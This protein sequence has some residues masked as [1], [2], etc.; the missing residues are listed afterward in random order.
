[1]RD[2]AMKSLNTKLVLAAFGIVAMLTGPAFAK[3]PKQATQAEAYDGI[4]GYDGNGA[5][6]EIPNPDQSGSG[7]Q[8]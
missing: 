3:Q 5:V 4:S 1:M 7:S 8:R 2:A 6:V